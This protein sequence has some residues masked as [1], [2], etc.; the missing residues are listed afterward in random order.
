MG[1]GLPTAPEHALP[2]A[3]TSCA[4][5]TLLTVLLAWPDPPGTVEV[6]TRPAYFALLTWFFWRTARATPALHSSA[7]R[8]VCSGFFVLWL[9]YTVAAAIRA[10]ELDDRYEAFGYLRTTCE[11]GAWFLLGT[12]LISYGLMLWIPQ[13]VRSHELLAEDTARQRGEL[14]RAASE[15]SELERRLVDA[16]RLSMLGELAAS[17]AHDLR[18]PLT[19]V[20]GTAE[21][22]CRRERSPQEVQEH[23]DVIRRNV[24]DADRILARLIDLAR[25]SEATT[26]E[27]DATAALAEVAELLRVEARR[28]GVHLLV[29]GPSAAV[30]ADRT[31]LQQALMNLVINAVHASEA[32]G[33]VS[34]STRAFGRHV[35]L[36]I[37]DRGAG[38]PRHVREG[39]F[40]PFFTTK[41][42]GTGLG[43]VSCRR[44][45]RD[46]GG[47][48]RLYP[49]ARGGARAVLWLPRSPAD[50]LAAAAA[51][52]DL[53]P[54]APC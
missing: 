6:L 45:A 52:E 36:R 11:Q 47:D 53:C 5:L 34:M 29:D 31:R 7:M 42:T 27:V 14:Q 49:R 33:E 2:G 16:D 9:G 8:L 43:L 54:A 1:T 51:D 3:R 18:N 23:T 19:V 13:V 44:V 25:P 20:K 28:R 24:D 39:L 22:L 35:A 10:A 21:S 50:T 26:E 17:I 41:E 38:L 32:G 12:T 40:R 48:L 37:E 30:R 46:L 15:R 4:L